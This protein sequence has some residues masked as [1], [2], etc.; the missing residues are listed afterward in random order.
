MQWNEE[1]G[2]ALVLE[3]VRLDPGHAESHVCL[4]EIYA[5]KG[6]YAAAWRHARAAEASGEREGVELLE[7]HKIKP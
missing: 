3:A 6:D 5:V 1:E 7:R 2:L 4:T